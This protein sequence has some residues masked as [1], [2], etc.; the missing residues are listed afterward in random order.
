[1]GRDFA[2]KLIGVRNFL[3][4]K[5]PLARHLQPVV[6]FPGEHLDINGILK[7]DARSAPTG[8]LE[9]AMVSSGVAR[10]KSNTVLYFDLTRHMRGEEIKPITVN[11]HNALWE[12]LQWPLLFEEGV[13]GF[14]FK[15]DGESVEST[16]GV[17]LS[18]RDYSRAMLF[19]NE[20]FGYAGRL[21]QEWLLSQY[22]RQVENQLNFLQ[23]P[24]FQ[25]KIHRADPLVRR[26]D[27]H[28]ADGGRGGE[29]IRMPA[30]VVGSKACVP[31]ALSTCAHYLL[32]CI[33]MPLSHLHPPP[34]AAT[35]RRKRTTRWRSRQ[36]TASP[37]ASSQ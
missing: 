20:R 33:Y 11:S 27:L 19:Q 31:R 30:S 3:L 26:E 1:L 21:M 17:K 5:H 9:M 24:D 25:Q 10:A 18:L 23:R 7:L 8:R 22:S 32:R 4:N 37:P 14:F 15:S 36:R 29:R 35:S 12:M 6:Q 28:A 34:C 16:E 2:N 13:G